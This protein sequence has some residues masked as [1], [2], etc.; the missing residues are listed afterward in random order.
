MCILTS[1]VAQSVGLVIGCAVDAQ[2]AVY[3]GPISTIPT[4]LF[5][6]KSYAT[7]FRMS[8]LRSSHTFFQGSAKNFQM[9]GAWYVF[10][11]LTP[12]RPPWKI[13]PYMEK[14]CGPPRT[15]FSLKKGKNLLPILPGQW[16]GWG[17]TS[18]YLGHFLLF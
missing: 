12:T 15:L 5:S 4:L 16:R 13:L 7:I 8:G 9:E 3:L 17:W 2:A 10:L 6:G 18:M 14:V 11:F 1:L